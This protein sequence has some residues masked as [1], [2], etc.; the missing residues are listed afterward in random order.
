MW[1]L[2]AQGVAWV[3]NNLFGGNNKTPQQP[4][5]PPPPINY[6]PVILGGFGLLVLV[7]IVSIFNKK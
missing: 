6:T 1:A 5:P 3:G 7:L 2:F 4:P